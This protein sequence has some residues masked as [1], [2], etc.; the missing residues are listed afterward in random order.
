VI[1]QRTKWLE[2]RG[3]CVLRFWNHEVLRHTD[4]IMDEIIRIAAGRMQQPRPDQPR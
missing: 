2:A 1:E 3:Y 4:I